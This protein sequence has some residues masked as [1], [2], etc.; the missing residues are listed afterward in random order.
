MLDFIRGVVRP[1]ATLVLVVAAVSFI[2]FNTPIPDWFIGTVSTVIG[3]WFG[4]R[5]STGSTNG[6]TRPPV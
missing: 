1:I 3:F 2:A 6:S 5:Q 4:Q